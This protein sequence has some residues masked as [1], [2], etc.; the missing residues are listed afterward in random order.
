M[1]PTQLKLKPELELPQL[2]LPILLEYPLL[3]KRVN[4]PQYE[5]SGIHN[6][7]VELKK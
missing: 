1:K 3:Q 4:N 5:L 6:L 2:K 7:I